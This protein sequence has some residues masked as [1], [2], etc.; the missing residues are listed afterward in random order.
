VIAASFAERVQTDAARLAVRT[1][2]RDWTYAEL[3]A[4]ARSLAEQRASTEQ[5][6]PLPNRTVG[7]QASD[8]AARVVGLLVAELLGMT[9]CL[10][11]TGMNP[12]NL[13]AWAEK[14]R[15]AELL[16][17]SGRWVET[18]FASAAPQ[19][20]S[21]T[22][23][24]HLPG[25]W[26]FTSGTTGPPQPVRH[27][28][29]A[30]ASAVHAT[31]R[32]HGERWLLAYDPGSFAGLQVM[33][34]ALLTGGTLSDVSQATPEETARRMLI[35][36]VT[37][38]SGTP[39]FWRMLLGAVEPAKWKRAAL[40]QITLGGEVVNDATLIALQAAFPQ[41]RISHIYA[42]SELGVCFS[43][44]DGRAGFP[45]E[46]LQNPPGGCQLRIST[47]GELE[48]LSHRRA[49]ALALENRIAPASASES[50]WLPTGD[51]VELRGERVYFVG[52]KSGVIH[53]GGGKVVP[54]EVEAILR[55]VAGVA[56]VRVS[57]QPSSV[58]GAIVRADVVVA[59]HAEVNAVRAA[60]LAAC[61]AQL[62]RHKVPATIEFHT[63]LPRTPSGKLARDA[64]A[65]TDLR[66]NP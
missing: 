46:Y 54:E 32:Y 31:A 59:A 65:A 50:D 17:A 15:L 57:G 47:E 27:T 52:R 60:L 4:K 49:V 41:A 26:L 42:T 2:D 61:Q 30:L 11:P 33:L 24:T 48:V 6:T 44:S 39:T 5:G 55:E 25:L 51:L 20:A 45:A 28:W 63:T 23:D 35:E 12:A 34:Q 22:S 18:P 9:P 37:Y 29:Q 64:E 3:L 1:D 7:I 56:E 19:A 40:E 36:Q 53:V 43:V 66:P 62:P 10:F 58:L 14:L 16:D 21:T 8:L 38:A 13:N